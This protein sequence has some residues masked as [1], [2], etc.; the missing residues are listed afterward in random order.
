MWLTEAQIDNAIALGKAGRAPIAM[1]G[2]FLGLSKG[3]VD[4]FIDG[5][6]SR[7]AS[8][9]QQATKQLRPFCEG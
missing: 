3:D 1:A 8:A 7:I 4:V 5:P 9:A 6:I 2:R